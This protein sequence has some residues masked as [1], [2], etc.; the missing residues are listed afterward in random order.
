MFSMIGFSDPYCMLGIMP[1]KPREHHGSSSDSAV[2]SSDDESKPRDKEKKSALRKFSASFKRRKDKD[3]SSV[4]DLLPAK[5][6]RTTSVK[7][8]TLNP[9]WNEKFRL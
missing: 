5:Y 7:S 6:I 4:R 3:R 9:E 1:G 2:F 8:N